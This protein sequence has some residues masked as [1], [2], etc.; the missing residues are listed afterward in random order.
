M[1]SYPW[2]QQGRGAPVPDVEGE[3]RAPRAD[4]EHDLQLRRHRRRAG[5]QRLDLGVDRVH[6]LERPHAARRPQRVARGS[7]TTVSYTWARRRPRGS[8]RGPPASARSTCSPGGRRHVAAD[9]RRHDGD[10]ASTRRPRARLLVRVPGPGG[11]PAG[12]LS[13]VEPRSEGLG[14][15]AGRR[16]PFAAVNLISDPIHGY[17]E[18]TKRLAPD[19]SRAAGLPPRTSPRTTCSTPRG[20]SASAGSASSRAPDG[21]SRPRST[22]G[23]RTGWASCTR[24]G[25]GRGRCTRRCGRRC[26]RSRPAS[27]SVRGP[28]RRDAADRGPPPRRGA[29]P[30]AHF[31]D[32]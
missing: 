11:R 29:R 18:L 14:A 1:S 12:Y 23:S 20:S 3:R 9:P 4:D 5:E 32:E 22:P 26:R 17:L 19:E 21:S 24:P 15:V 31:F 6:G 2:A 28:R 13:A 16:L 7:G 25:C 8:R 10:V 27:P 30:F